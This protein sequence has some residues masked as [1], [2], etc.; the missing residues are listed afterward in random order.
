MVKDKLFTKLSGYL[1]GQGTCINYL[2]ILSAIALCVKLVDIRNKRKSLRYFSRDSV[3][4]AS[5]RNVFAFCG[6][7]PKIIGVG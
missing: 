1:F 2:Y 7:L 4:A 6:S 5:M 3:Y